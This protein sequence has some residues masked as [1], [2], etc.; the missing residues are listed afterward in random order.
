MLGAPM[1]LL[2]GVLSPTLRHMDAENVDAA[3][4]VDLD[5][6]GVSHPAVGSLQDDALLMPNAERIEAAFATAREGMSGPRDGSVTRQ[7]SLAVQAWLESHIYGDFSDHSGPDENLI[8]LDISVADDGAIRADGMLFDWE[9]FVASKARESEACVVFLESLRHSQMLEVFLRNQLKQRAARGNAVNG[10]Q[11]LA[12]SR[13]GLGEVRDG[14]SPLIPPSD[15]SGGGRGERDAG[16]I[17]SLG[18]AEESIVIEQPTLSEPAED[19][20]QHHAKVRPLIELEPIGPLSEVDDAPKGLDARQGWVSFSGARELRKQ[21]VE[22][23]QP[24]P[25][26]AKTR[27]VSLTGS[28]EAAI[29]EGS[30]ARSSIKQG[31]SSL[32]CSELAHGVAVRADA[33]GELLVAAAADVVKPVVAP[34]KRL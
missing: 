13:V 20:P 32:K 33:F 4:V 34:S 24:P 30:G 29:R 26:P 22:L 9:G 19:L 17:S 10:G 6:L 15:D 18:H 1:P 12:S 7:V 25:H 21:L 11:D 27:A 8:G 14:M 31:S 16:K 5:R 2:A 23:S 28:S 3:V